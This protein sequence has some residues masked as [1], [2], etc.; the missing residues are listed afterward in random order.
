MVYA[1]PEKFWQ[2]IIQLPL[3]STV[4]HALE[5]LDFAQFPVHMK[6]SETR[7]AVFGQ[8]VKPSNIL[9]EHDRIEILKPLLRDPK[10]I[11]RQRA[12]LNPYKKLKK[13]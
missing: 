9:H 13:K 3:G 11:R 5:K 12:E 10:E 8:L 7:L 6:L 4:Q 2:Q 1:E